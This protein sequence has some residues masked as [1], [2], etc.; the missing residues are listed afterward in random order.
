MR[1]K[2]FKLA[3]MMLL[4]IL[5]PFL[6]LAQDLISGKVISTLD[7]SPI[8][9]VSVLIKGG[10][11][12]TMTNVDGL[13]SIRAAKGA[14]LVFSGIGIKSKEVIANDNASLIVSVEQNQNMMNE[15]TVTALGIKKETKRLGYSV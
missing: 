13:F 11:K 6:L 2:L 3:G 10:S 14:V 12:G 8:S 4:G 5:S 9:S 7:Q 15:V 1:V